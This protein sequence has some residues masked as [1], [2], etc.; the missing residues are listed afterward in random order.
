MIEYVTQANF[1]PSEPFKGQKGSPTIPN[2]AI[3]IADMFLQA[4]K[5]LLPDIVN[6][7]DGLES[8]EDDWS[9]NPQDLT[10]LD[11]VLSTVDKGI[12]S[13]VK[14][15]T[16]RIEEPTATPDSTFVENG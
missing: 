1:S 16:K 5:G 6:Y 13:C 14:E 8:S 2:Q 9:R 7:D 15:E 4:S 3:S 12:E 11:S 10:D